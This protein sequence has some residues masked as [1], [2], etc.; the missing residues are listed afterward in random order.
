M[1]CDN[2]SI[3][4][5][6]YSDKLFIADTKEWSLSSQMTSLHDLV[7][8]LCSSYALVEESS[9]IDAPD[10]KVIPSP[11]AEIVIRIIEG[12]VKLNSRHYEIRIYP[13]TDEIDEL[14]IE[15]HIETPFSVSRTNISLVADKEILNE[16]GLYICSLKHKNVKIDVSRVKIASDGQPE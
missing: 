1:I 11:T 12:M 14:Y 2:S 7:S 5:K 3:F 6:A 16:V 13:D 15:V 8:R 4:S 9:D 10:N